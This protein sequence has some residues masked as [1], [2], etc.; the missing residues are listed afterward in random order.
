MKTA[1]RKFGNS[2]GAII[3]AAL[4]REL[5]LNENDQM[6]V[7]AENGR[8]V[9]EPFSKAEYSL[10]ELLAQCEPEAMVLDEQDKAWL[11]DSPVGTEVV[12]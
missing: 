11:N 5:N 12:E 7:K 4:L 8:I 2:K 9:L 10:D 6:D 1:I 3:P